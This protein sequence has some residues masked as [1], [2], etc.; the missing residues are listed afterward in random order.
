MARRSN[1]LMSIEYRLALLAEVASVGKSNKKG[2][3]KSLPFP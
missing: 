3:I 1:D 2:S